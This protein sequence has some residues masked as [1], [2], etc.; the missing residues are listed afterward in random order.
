MTNRLRNE[1]KMQHKNNHL[2]VGYWSYLRRGRE[3]PDQA[4]IQPQVLA[5]LLPHVFILDVADPGRPL[6]R[7][8]G[9]SLCECHRGELKGTN[10]FEPWEQESRPVLAQAMHRSLWQQQPALISSFAVTATRNSV[11]LETVIAPLNTGTEEA[12]RFIGMTHIMSDPAPLVSNA[13]IF[14]RVT[15]AKLI[16]EETLDALANSGFSTP[17]EVR[18]APFAPHVPTLRALPGVKHVRLVV[19]DQ[20]QRPALA[21]RVPT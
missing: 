14:Q 9:T 4:D 16:H 12:P 7:L 13:M 15:L 2:F 11:E 19:S 5:G 10:F 8:A 6:Y 1:W 21:S 20:R 17:A 3:A 18:R